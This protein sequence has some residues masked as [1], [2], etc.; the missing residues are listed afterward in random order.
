MAISQLYPNTRPTLN[1]NFARSKRLDPRITFTRN[2]T[3]TYVG[4]DGLIKTAVAGEAR[5]DHNSN[6]DSL[7]L[8]I[9]E[10]RTNIIR[11][12]TNLNNTAQWNTSVN[13][14]SLNQAANQGWMVA[15]A[16]TT[17][18]VAPDGTYSACKLSGNTASTYDKNYNVHVVP[19]A[20]NHSMAQTT[21]YSYSVFINDPDGVIDSRYTLEFQHGSRYSN[22]NG[23]AI[24][25]LVNN[26]VTYNS[27]VTSSAPGKIE[28]YPNGWKK[29]TAT[30]N[31]TSAG[32]PR[33]YLKEITP[34]TNNVTQFSAN[35]EKFYVWGFQIEEASFPTS[36]IPTSGS[37][38]TRAADLCQITGNTWD[39]IFIEGSNSIV[40]DGSFNYN[41]NSSTFPNSFAGPNLFTLNSDT[42]Q[43]WYFYRENTSRGPVS[44][45]GGGGT[46]E[47]FHNTV[48]QT[49]GLFKT[50]FTWDVPNDRT[51]S[52]W[53]G[54]LSSSNPQ[55]RALYWVQKLR[56][57]SNAGITIG[58]QNTANRT[59]LNGCVSRIAIY[60]AAMTD[61]ALE[62]LTL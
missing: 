18:I 50:C 5:F 37:T 51:Y 52:A 4:S 49:T 40:A 2:S 3:A 62:A 32:G 43:V 12:S 20:S 31:S 30:F 24:F 38:V 25:D 53:N 57:N 60:N 22:T 15:T 44:G 17:E 59:P 39:N 47:F 48:T 58:G 16:N 6:G 29:L 9:E 11:E 8:L 46:V 27:H 56:N 19:N 1:L 61:S 55:G 13:P 7:G 54:D 10:S 45:V 35:G 36:Y 34:R 28:P 33:F 41:V 23:R 42:N 26:T 14:G 21:V